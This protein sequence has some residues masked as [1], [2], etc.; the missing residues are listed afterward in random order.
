MLTMAFSLFPGCVEIG[1]GE[2]GR[3][4]DRE[5]VGSSGKSGRRPELVVGG[6]AA[7]GR[8]RSR[9]RTEQRRAGSNFLY[10]QETRRP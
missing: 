5:R 3:R 6:V 7:V 2:T 9:P 10:V 4:K 1:G 8:R